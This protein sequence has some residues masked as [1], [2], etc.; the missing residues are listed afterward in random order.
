MFR[1]D[2]PT[3]APALPTPQQPLG[4]SGFFTGGNEAT[5]LSPTRV[6]ADWLNATQE[7][8]AHVIEAAGIVLS[9]TDRTQLFQALQKLTRTRLGAPMTL[10][11]SP[12]GNDT[13]N[14]LSP[15]QA[16]ASVTAAY[17]NLRD[18]YD[19]G[20][21]QVTIQLADGNYGPQSVSGA[22]VGPAVR[23]V[24]NTG[25]PGNVVIN[26]P[27]GFAFAASL[28]ANVVV[29]SFKLTAAG[30]AADYS[31]LPIGLYAS[32]GAIIGVGNG[33]DFGACQFAQMAAA[34]SGVIVAAAAGTA[35]SIDGASPIHAWAW[36][37]GAVAIAD[38]SITL[39]GTLA[40][41]SAFA[42]AQSCGTMQAW[43]MTFHGTATGKCHLAQSNGVIQTNQGSLTYFPGSVAGTTDT[44]GQFF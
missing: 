41:S 6:S 7:E 40:F 10:Y 32:Y 36:Q 19:L 17:A 39:V 20:G 29:S 43:G 22:I 11:V 24:G 28:G 42:V 8:I 13:N 44:G 16:F 26:N 9:K 3:A 31:T 30:S 18:H 2:D 14:G 37:N 35:Y 4:P 5:G 12:G 33:M 23:I 21:Q 25:A 34:S 27:N 15:Q 38:C 1:I